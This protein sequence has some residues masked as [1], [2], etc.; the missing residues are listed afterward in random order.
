[1]PSQPASVMIT[2]RTNVIVLLLVLAIFVGAAASVSPPKTINSA[3]RNTLQPTYRPT[4][5]T[6]NDIESSI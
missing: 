3:Y 4:P 2:Q 1:M 6:S 5:T